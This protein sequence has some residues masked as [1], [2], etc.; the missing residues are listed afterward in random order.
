[1]AIF[2]E[3]G[4][5]IIGEESKERLGATG[6]MASDKKLMMWD[7]FYVRKLARNFASQ[8]SAFYLK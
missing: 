6:A 8:F 4:G 1:M 2:E 3:P 5:L 7:Q